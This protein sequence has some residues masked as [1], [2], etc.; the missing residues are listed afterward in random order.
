LCGKARKMFNTHLLNYINIFARLIFLVFYFFV[1]IISYFC[2]MK[3]RLFYLFFLAS[4]LAACSTDFNINAEWQEITVVYGLLNQKETTHYI[5]I[6]KAFLGDGNALTM[7]QIEDSSSY[8]NNLEVKVEEWKNGAMTNF[9]YCDTTTIYNKEP[10]LFYYPKQILYKFDAP[11]LYEDRTYKLSIKN[12]ISGKLVTSETP[13]VRD[14]SITK[15]TMGW[16]ASFTSVSSFEVKW[17]SGKYGKRYQLD[18]RFYYREVQ[19]GTTDTSDVIA[20]DWLFPAVKSSG[21][22]G[23]EVLTTSFRGSAFYE[24]LSYKIPV[25]P[26]YHRVPGG[27]AYNVDFIFSVAGDDFNT[28][29][30]VAEPSTGIV[31]EKPSYTNINNGIGI[32]SSR[33]TKTQNY[34]MSAPSVTELRSGALFNFTSNLNFQ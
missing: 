5:K 33:Y 17:E 12:K 34:N 15:P 21:I 3:K 10:G 1:K 4:L 26:G 24:N 28:Y 18:I 27:S 6:N 29:M 19:V 8:F 25:K 13:M 11:S 31:Q 2:I 22:N 9:W 23:G 20:V 30:E 7:A 14:F 32:F 16:Q